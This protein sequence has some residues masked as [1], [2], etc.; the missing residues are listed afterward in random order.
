[1]IV[2]RRL[3]ALALV[4]TAG[5]GAL[6]LVRS[7]DGDTGV[8]REP[9]AGGPRRTAGTSPATAPATA[10]D[11]VTPSARPGGSAPAVLY[12]DRAILRRLGSDGTDE[13]VHRFP[14]ADVFAAPGSDLVAYVTPGVP[15]VHIYDVASGRDQRIGLG[16]SPRWD[17]GGQ[18][19]AFLRPTEAPCEGEG[20]RVRAEVM[21]VN[22]VSGDQRVVLAKGPW[23]L[24]GWAGERVVAYDADNLRVVAVA[25][26]GAPIDL[27][28]QPNGFWGASPDGRWLVT[29]RRGRYRFERLDPAG[30]PT[31]ATVA[32]AFDRVLGEGAWSPDAAAVAAIALGKGSSEVVLFSPGAPEPR[33]VDGSAGAAGNLVWSED[34]TAFMFAQVDP[35]RRGRLR[36]VVCRLDAAR[37]CEPLFSWTEGVSLLKLYLTEGG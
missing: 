22:A 16:L 4:A 35:E 15:V 28:I 19:L 30:A 6:L 13:V 34:G 17:Q 8:V 23:G 27:G 7:G 37:S 24:L 21:V 12:L 9:R 2:V 26:G 33:A 25:P 32:I 18:R 10:A 11:E 20:C 31:G 3:V 29:L 5:G 14:A 1:M 36:A